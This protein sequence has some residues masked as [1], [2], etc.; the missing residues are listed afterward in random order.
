[1]QVVYSNTHENEQLYKHLEQAAMEHG[2]CLS[3][4]SKMYSASEQ[5]ADQILDVLVEHSATRAVV[6]LLDNSQIR[7]L[8]GS[9][10]RF[11][12]RG[13]FTWIGTRSWGMDIDVVEGYEQ[14]AEGAV[15]FALEEET[16][17]EFAQYY[18]TLKPENNDYNPWFGDFWQE[19]FQCYLPG[20]SQIYARECNTTRESL[21]GDDFAPEL[22]YIVRAVDEIMIAID[23][24]WRSQCGN[25]PSLCSAFINHESRWGIINS[26]ILEARSTTN[27]ERAAKYKVVNFRGAHGNCL[28]H[29]YAQVGNTLIVL[30]CSTHYWYAG[31]MV[32]YLLCEI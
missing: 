8:F 4:I 31:L 6:L 30:L 5:E 16:P 10:Q 9:A 13:M 3:T 2:I 27:G 26:K 20:S 14:I 12:T 22:T 32:S 23:S 18:S 11:N 17:E 7:G 21:S 28:Q 15:T 29:C 19:K 25:S 1:M 24:A